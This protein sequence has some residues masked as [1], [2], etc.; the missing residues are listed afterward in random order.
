MLKKREE[1]T[2]SQQK[3][4]KRSRL[5]AVFL[6]EILYFLFSLD[7]DIV[8]LEKESEWKKMISNQRKEGLQMK[9][10][11][12]VVDFQKDF[13]DGSL[14]FEQASELETPICN[15]ISEYRKNGNTVVFTFDTHRADYL[16]TQEGK[17][18]PVK[19]CLEQTEGWQLFGKVA[20]M[21]QEDDPVFE[22][23]T[24]G[25]L[26]LAEYL[27]REKFDSVELVGL[28]SN[29]CVLSNAVLAKAALPQAEIIVDSHCT[30]SNDPEMN[31]KALDILKGIH[32]AVL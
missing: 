10:V 11:L 26:A 15:K 30:A 8:N 19:H 24:F 32:I 4:E 16:F 25:S 7:Y 21:K 3:R 17:H 18:L 23:E 29:I 2:D 5:Q 9:K 14:G 22:K 20:T 12:V 13:V 31:Q 6:P 27:K 28:V 1:K